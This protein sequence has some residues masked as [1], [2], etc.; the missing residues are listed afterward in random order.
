MSDLKVFDCFMIWNFD[1]VEM[2]ELENLMVNV[3]IIV[4]GVEVCKE[5]CGVYVCEDYKD[6]DFV[7]CNDVEWCKY[8]L[9]WV[10]ENGIVKMDYCLVVIELL[11][12]FQNGGIDLK[13]IVLKVCVY[14]VFRSGFG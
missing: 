7:G 3:I 10:D 4:Y 1:L 6:G 2:L 12:L 9:I 14:Q 5:L 8:M 13:K 11:I